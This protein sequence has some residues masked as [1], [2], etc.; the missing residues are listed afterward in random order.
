VNVLAPGDEWIGL[1]RGFFSAGS[2]SLLVSQWVV[3]D[4]ATARLMID[5]YSYLRKGAGPA[6]ALRYAQCQLLAEK[7]HPYFWAPFVVLGR[8]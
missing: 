4:E 6:A 5:F 3:D 7:P 1:A 8:W 2:P